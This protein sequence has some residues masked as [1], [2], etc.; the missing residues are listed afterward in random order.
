MVILLILCQPNSSLMY[1]PPLPWCCCHMAYYHFR[2]LM[3]HLRYPQPRWCSTRLMYKRAAFC[4]THAPQACHHVMPWQIPSCCATA[5]TKD[6]RARV[7][8]LNT[9][10]ILM[11]KV[12]IKGT[13]WQQNNHHRTSQCQFIKGY[14][15]ATNQKTHLLFKWRGTSSCN[16]SALQLAWSIINGHG[17]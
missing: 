10:L 1:A 6:I 13:T 14:S 17:P 3:R 8:H 16:T 15:I 11:A 4:V 9:T 5:A 2:P 12:H 7:L